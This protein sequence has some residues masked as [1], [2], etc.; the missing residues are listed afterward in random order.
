MNERGHCLHIAQ[1]VALEKLVKRTPTATTCTVRQHLGNRAAHGSHVSA[2]QP[3]LPA[4][5]TLATTFAT[6][7]PSRHG[8]PAF[9]G[10]GVVVLVVS[11]VPL[12][13]CHD[14]QCLVLSLCGTA[15]DAALYWLWPASMT[16]KAWRRP[17]GWSGGRHGR[18]LV[19]CCASA[20]ASYNARKPALDEIGFRRRTPQAEVLQVPG[21]AFY[22]PQGLQ[23]PL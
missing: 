22:V 2:H 16:L 13:G 15:P 23:R 9:S 1:C 3:L 4:M 21:M 17:Q 6:A 18:P 10:S 12:L 7:H 8:C 19:P 14:A 20:K 5:S 11:C